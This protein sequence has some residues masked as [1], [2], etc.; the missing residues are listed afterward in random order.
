MRTICT[1]CKQ[2][3]EVEQEFIG[4]SVTCPNCGNDFCVQKIKI[5]AKCGTA[6]PHNAIICCKCHL[7]LTTADA[8]RSEAQK[9]DDTPPKDGA[10]FREHL[11]RIWEKSLPVLRFLIHLAILAAIAFGAWKGYQYYQKRKAAQAEEARRKAAEE[12]R[13]KKIEAKKQVY[14]KLCELGERLNTLRLGKNLDREAKNIFN[15]WYNAANRMR[16]DAKKDGIIITQ[17]R[18]GGYTWDY[19]RI[20]FKGKEEDI[21]KLTKKVAYRYN[22]AFWAH[23]AKLREIYRVR[24]ENIDQFIREYDA[25]MLS[26]ELPPLTERIKADL[27]GLALTSRTDAATVLKLKH[28]PEIL[29]T[30]KNPD[31]IARLMGQDFSTSEKECLLIIYLSD[32]NWSR[33]SSD[34]EKIM[35]EENFPLL[36]LSKSELAEI[37]RKVQS[38]FSY[39]GNDPKE[40][41]ALKTKFRKKAALQFLSQKWRRRLTDLKTEEYQEALRYYK[42]IRMRLEIARKEVL[43]QVIRDN[44]RHFSH[45]DF[46]TLEYDYLNRK[47]LSAEPKERIEADY[48]R[49]M[50]FAKTSQR[51]GFITYFDERYFFFCNN[52]SSQLMGFGQLLDYPP[53]NWEKAFPEEQVVLAD[54]YSRKKSQNDGSHRKKS[55]SGDDDNSGD[56]EYEAKAEMYEQEFAIMEL[57][58]E[59]E[60]VDRII[61]ALQPQ[62]VP[63]IELLSG[64]FLYP[65]E[66]RAEVLEESNQRVKAKQRKKPRRR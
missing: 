27:R 14:P 44:A 22:R 5:C 39:S 25:V 46:N 50:T 9:N 43:T 19:D 53:P 4:Q 23:N 29:K 17:N 66:K 61:A 1:H 55:Q 16:E 15:K 51:K 40:A 21:K 62:R 31:E 49:V 3:F 47:T 48:A 20:R 2:E 6:N 42:I 64:I 45:Y 24:R 58:A 56:D 38:D 28:F 12:E 11:G 63:N 35:T 30:V 13:R 65:E 26:G 37:D 8:V 33:I 57:F 41:E 36:L 10:S 7:D 18:F 34:A 54:T 59:I 32:R 52:V 60:R